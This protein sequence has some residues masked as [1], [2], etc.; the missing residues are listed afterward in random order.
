L[1]LHRLPE[2][3]RRSR[4]L[5][6]CGMAAALVAVPGVAHAQAAPLD[7]VTEQLQDAGQELG[8]TITGG[9]GS[10]GPKVGSGSTGPEVLGNVGPGTNSSTGTTTS[11]ADST[12]SFTPPDL[13]QLQAL[14]ER[15][16][17][18]DECAT[19]V[20]DD[21]TE[22]VSSIPATVQAIIAQLQAGLAAVQE[23]PNALPEDLQT[24][25]MTLLG[26]LGGTP[27]ADADA[28]GIPL[29]TAVG[30][31]VTDFLANCLPEPEV[32]TGAPQTTAPPAAVTSTPPP[33]APTS[34]APV[35][36]LGYAP[37]G[38]DEDTDDD[39]GL[40]LLGGVLLLSGA[41]AGSW[42]W[43]RRAASSRG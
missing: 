17:V 9:S 2:P 26:G 19:A 30:N 33:A 34:A 27:A 15:L 7:Q 23:D 8:T 37:T 14:F 20:T 12:P 38:A 3:P 39:G 22:V 43:S 35:A 25:L 11:D 10:T 36:Y 31:L 40:A 16:E 29:V 6:V 4:R 24:Q 1:S 13:S 42:M 41:A 5:L 18:P 21:L 28:D 32:P